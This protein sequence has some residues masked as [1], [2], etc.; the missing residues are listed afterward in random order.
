VAAL[1][2]CAITPN[3]RRASAAERMV[4]GISFLIFIA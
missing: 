3:E 4:A 2:L 1:A